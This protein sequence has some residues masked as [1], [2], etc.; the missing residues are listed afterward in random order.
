MPVFWVLHVW[1]VRNL[2][3]M[4]ASSRFSLLVFAPVLVA[5][6]LPTWFLV[7]NAVLFTVSGIAD[8]TISLAS[9]VSFDMWAVGP[10]LAVLGLFLAGRALY[11]LNLCDHFRPGAWIATWAVGSA[12]GFVAKWFG[13]TVFTS[14]GASD[15]TTAD[16]LCMTAL[17]AA[18]L[19]PLAQVL[20]VP[21]L[22]AVSRMWIWVQTQER[23]AHAGQ[24]K[25]AVEQE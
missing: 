22:I 10:V 12:A 5:F 13:L 23:T 2:D 14:L 4:Q 16:F 3:P 18:A 6:L 1:K 7:P 11:R 24:G 8:P 21:W 25:G 17:V 20:L 15:H 19:T 9:I